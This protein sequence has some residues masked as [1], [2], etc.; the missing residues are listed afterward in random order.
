MAF[1][2]PWRVREERKE[3]RLPR[4][5]LSEPIVAYR[6]W[7]TAGERL[8]SCTCGCVWQP[9]RR[10][11]ATC[12]QFLPHPAVP[13]WDCRCGFYAYKSE[14]ALAASTYVRMGH[15]PTVRGRVALWGRV[16]DH[17]LGYRA[18]FAYPQLFYLNG[19]A[20]DD[21]IRRLAEWYAV[22]CVPS[23]LLTH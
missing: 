21:V 2:V 11:T 18:Q 14:E 19:D 4:R 15:E 16:V 5:M 17:D 20:L 10:M 13:S 1:W 8:L 12:N 3:P 9:R 7:R 6:A 23:R 22:E